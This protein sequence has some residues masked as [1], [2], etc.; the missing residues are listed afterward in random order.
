MSSRYKTCFSGVV[1]SLDGGS[2]AIWPTRI[3]V[4]DLSFWL[5]EAVFLKRYLLFGLCLT[6]IQ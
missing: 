5:M 6:S 2:Y 4:V 3:A 1:S